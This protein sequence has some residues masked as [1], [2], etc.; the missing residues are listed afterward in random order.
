MRTTTEIAS[1]LSRVP[2]RT[3]QRWANEARI[4]SEERGGKV[5]VNPAEVEELAQK[6]H[7]GRLPRERN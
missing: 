6:R 2:V 4:T 1:R 3:I 7:A 5:L